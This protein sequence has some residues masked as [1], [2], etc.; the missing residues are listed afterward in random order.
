MIQ[1]D[2]APKVVML[3]L[4]LEHILYMDL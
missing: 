2:Y 4:I 3:L 1:K